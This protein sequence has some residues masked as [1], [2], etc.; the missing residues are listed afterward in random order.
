M[1]R[2]EN[3]LN[4]PP[5]GGKPHDSEPP[6]HRRDAPLAPARAPPRVYIAYDQ[7]ASRPR[8]FTCCQNN[9]PSLK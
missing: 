1:H 6:L 8:T 5:V 4:T 9:A 2:N 7:G 3:T